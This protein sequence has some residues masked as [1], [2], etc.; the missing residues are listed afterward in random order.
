MVRRSYGGN[1]AKA[2][3]CLAAGFTGQCT[4]RAPQARRCHLFTGRWRRDRCRGARRRYALPSAPSLDRRAWRRRSRLDFSRSCTG[5]QR[6]PTTAGGAAALRPIRP[7]IARSRIRVYWP[8]MRRNFKG[9][10][11]DTIIQ[12]DER[13]F[14]VVCDDSDPSDGV[15]WRQQLGVCRPSCD[16]STQIKQYKGLKLGL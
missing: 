10:V 14:H 3:E 2:K 7:P 13:I 9:I 15:S 11:D 8:T 5:T 4:G 12:D 6:E 16:T 1:G